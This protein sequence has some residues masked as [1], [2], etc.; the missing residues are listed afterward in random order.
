MGFEFGASGFES[1]FE[2]RASGFE[3]RAS[4][5]EFRAS[6]LGLRVWGLGP[7]GLG[8]T[9]GSSEPKELLGVLGLGSWGFRGKGLRC[10][11]IY[12]M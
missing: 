12:S 6:G 10:S 11:I 4:G 7:I 3:F 8:F 9:D 5:F 2:F 1:G